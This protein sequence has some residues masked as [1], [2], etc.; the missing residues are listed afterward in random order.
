MRFLYE[1]Y[2]EMYKFTQPKEDVIMDKNGRIDLSASRL[3]QRINTEKRK[4]ENNPYIPYCG[5]L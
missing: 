1:P 5:G 3:L 2:A 4:Q